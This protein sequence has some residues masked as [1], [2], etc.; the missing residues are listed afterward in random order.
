MSFT[1]E[2]ELKSKIINGL[3]IAVES[4]V[5]EIH[6]N[7]EQI[8]EDVV[9]GAYS[10]S[11]Y[12]RTGD[13]GNAWDTR[14]GAAGSAV[15][16]EF[17]YNSSGMGVSSPEEGQHVS[18]IDGSVQTLNMPD[19]IYQGGMGCIQRPTNRDAWKALDRFLTNSMI[20]SIFET[21]LSRSGMP[22]KRNNGAITVQK[23]K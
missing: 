7:N 16:G 6:E 5:K 19:I 10:P 23:W 2:S 13:F 11:W 22:W 8:I 1:S 20:R 12:A 9:Y 17:Y 21:G 18:V 3:T 4:T 14:V 15:E